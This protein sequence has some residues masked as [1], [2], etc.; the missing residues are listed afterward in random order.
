[1]RVGLGNI[2]SIDG[3]TAFGFC[4]TTLLAVVGKIFLK[5]GCLVRS[6]KQYCLALLPEIRRLLE[7]N[8]SRSGTLRKKTNNTRM[9]YEYY[10]GMLRLG[11]ED[12]I[13]ALFR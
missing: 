1:M 11:R 8:K 12:G 4:T 7:Q 2:S 10:Y 5:N 3:R 13:L 6:T 9:Y